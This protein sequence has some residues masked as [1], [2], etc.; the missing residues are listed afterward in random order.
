MNQSKEYQRNAERIGRERL[1]TSLHTLLM[2]FDTGEETVVETFDASTMGLGLTANLSA[3]ILREN[4]GVLLRPSD[5]SFNL[6]GEVVF[7]MEHGSDKCRF[8][9]QFTQTIA[10]HKYLQ[11]IE[12]DPS[13]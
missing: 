4:V 9:V 8:G 5:N 12:G 7:V 13:S 11:L 2:V 10:I 6:I 3:E 1:P